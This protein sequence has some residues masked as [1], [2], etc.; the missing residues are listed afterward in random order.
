MMKLCGRVIGVA[1]LLAGLPIGSYAALSDEVSFIEIYAGVSMETDAYAVE[2]YVECSG[3]VTG[4]VG[5]APF[6]S[7]V[8]EWDDEWAF[9][10][11]APASEEQPSV[12]GDWTLTFQ[13]ADGTSASTVVPFMRADGV[14]AL[15]EI[16]SCPQLTVPDFSRG[17]VVE[18]NVV[19]KWSQP[20]D[21]EANV[22]G[23]G[24]WNANTDEDV[25]VDFSGDEL[26]LEEYGPVDLVPGIEEIWIYNGYAVEG[27]N[28]EGI[29]F[30]VA[31][32]ASYDYAFTVLPAPVPA[33]A[34]TNHVSSVE[35]YAGASLESEEYEVEVEVECD[36]T[37]TGI[38]CVAPFDTV[39]LELDYDRWEFEG[40]APFSE[41]QPPIDGD[42]VFTFFFENGSS[43]STV[44]PFEQL[45]GSFMPDVDTC[46]ELLVPDLSAGYLFETN[47]IIRWDTPFDEEANLGGIGYWNSL[48]DEDLDFTFADDDLTQQQFGPV[49]LEAGI[50]EMWIYNGFVVEGTNSVGLPY[51]VVRFASRD[52]DVSVIRGDWDADGDHLSNAWEIEHFGDLTNGLALA[53]DDEDGADNLTEFYTG[54]DP[55]SD[56]SVYSLT[57]AISNMLS[58]KQ[59]SWPALLPNRFCVVWGAT[60][61][62]DGFVLLTNQVS[63]TLYIDKEQSAESG[64][65]QLRVR[66]EYLHESFAP[67]INVDVDGESEDW[68]ALAPRLVDEAGNAGL[69]SGL[70]ITG[71]YFARGADELFVRI[72]RAG[73]DMPDVNEYASIWLNLEAVGSGS[74][75]AV[76]ISGDNGRL[77]WN[78]VQQIVDESDWNE[79]SE[80]A[81][82]VPMSSD[83]PSIELSIP[84]S[85]VDFSGQYR[86]SIFSHYSVDGM[87]ADGSNAEDG[88][89]SGLVSIP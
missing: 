39:E 32:F 34:I 61:L 69:Y 27:E 82:N 28:D 14:T 12:D 65:Y 13:F 48:S 7:F 64:F 54:T 63:G 41:S 24:Y 49:D 62:Q 84:V 78:S 71:V 86:V 76:N 1:A 89:N 59:L 50:E 36:S 29:S 20:F 10:A 2:V 8:C 5:V 31:R 21:N 6:D 18:T 17:S 81:S 16:S 87:F 80:R 88:D 23:L 4:V 68:G 46:P 3:S 70:D 66:P 30:F 53:D 58:G 9:Y 26:K 75:Y 19:L 15:P 45:N 35:I 37:V 79:S 43:N 38:V 33:E 22:A 25:D 77:S 40:S 73:V 47:V 44:I 55:E 67:L 56:G 74:S 51:T 60:S 42:W 85:A 11:E 83:G 52:Y 72:D 57:V